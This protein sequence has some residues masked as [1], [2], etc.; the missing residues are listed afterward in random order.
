MQLILGQSRW[1]V[2]SASVPS[3]N[4]CFLKPGSGQHPD[5]QPFS[6]AGWCSQGPKPHELE[7]SPLLWQS[8][9]TME[10]AQ[11]QPTLPGKGSTL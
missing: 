9:V 4:R 7:L 1:T 11:R 6:P 2:I 3:A 8:E 10:S 5:S